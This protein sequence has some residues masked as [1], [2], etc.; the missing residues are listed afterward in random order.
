LHDALDISDWLILVLDSNDA[1][2]ATHG[3]HGNGIRHTFSLQLIRE[4][5]ADL[6]DLPSW[7]LSCVL[8]LPRMN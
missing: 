3:L 1:P 5:K 4:A 6:P 8:P 7:S 2:G